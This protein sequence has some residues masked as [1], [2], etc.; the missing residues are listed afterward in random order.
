MCC[1]HT[2][3]LL[4]KSFYYLQVQRV[5]AIYD[6]D[7]QGC[8]ELGFRKGD[9]IKVTQKVD[10]SWWRGELNGHEGMFPVTYVERLPD[11]HH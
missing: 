7:A 4:I 10:E 3:L 9:I 5:R 6:F 2:C 1:L 11:D 8:D